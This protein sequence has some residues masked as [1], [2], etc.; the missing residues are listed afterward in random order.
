MMEGVKL[1]EELE[2]VPFFIEP[3]ESFRAWRVLE[4]PK[5]GLMLRSITHKVGWPHRKPMIAHCLHQLKPTWNEKPHTAPN[6]LHRCGIYSVKTM[7]DAL[8][9]GQASPNI[10]WGKVAI[11]GHVLRYKLGYI[12]EYAYPRGPLQLKI[13]P[14]FGNHGEVA[15]E[16]EKLYG[17]KFEPLS[18]E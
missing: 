6:V 9:W 18:V 17:V 10:C 2:D 4:H 7:E 1:D 14:K 3:I 11:W 16:L 15:H 8:R 5:R 12:S 13:D